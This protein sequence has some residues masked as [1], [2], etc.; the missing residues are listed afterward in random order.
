MNKEAKESWPPLTSW[1]AAALPQQL[2]GWPSAGLPD[3]YLTEALQAS[4]PSAA[5]VQSAPPAAKTITHAYLPPQ[6][7]TTYAVKDGPG[8]SSYIAG[9]AGYR[10][11]SY[12]P[13]PSVGGYGRP[14]LEARRPVAVPN[15]SPIKKPLYGQPTPTEDSYEQGKGS[16]AVYNE[17]APRVNTENNRVQ[18]QNSVSADYNGGSSATYSDSGSGAAGNDYKSQNEINYE[19]GRLKS[20]SGDYSGGSSPVDNETGGYDESNEL[21]NENKEQ[22]YVSNSVPAVRIPGYKKKAKV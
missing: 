1:P 2:T 12:A 18:F 20:V 21:V 7:L 17:N 13:S 22:T 15:K 4:W 6:Y 3:S 19:D 8:L 10:G 11:G 16:A 5:P 14:P 9:S